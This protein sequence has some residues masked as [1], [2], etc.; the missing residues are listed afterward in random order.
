M[1]MHK[2]PMNNTQTTRRTFLSGLG[3]T[4]VT[5]LMPGMAW[6]RLSCDRPRS[7]TLNNANTGES[8]K[9]EFYDGK[10]YNPQELS[11]LNDFFRDFRRDDVIRIDPK[12][13][14]YLYDLTKLLEISKPVTL[15]SGYRSP[16]TN[17]MLRTRMRTVAKKSYHTRGQA[18]D[19]RIPGVEL[20]YLYRAAMS[21]KAGGVGYYPKSNFLHI[22]TGP[23]RN[24]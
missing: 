7:L 18:M 11:K 16:A 10:C 15:L 20:K 8:L 21:M 13:F 1:S 3:L 22:D 5:T 12:L 24:W 14:D 19:L 17:N 23:F 9:A 4:A 2:L 6:G